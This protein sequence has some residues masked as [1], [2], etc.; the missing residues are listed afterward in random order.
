M[1][2]CTEIIIALFLLS[3]GCGA[4]ESDQQPGEEIPISGDSAGS[5][6]ARQVSSRAISAAPTNLTVAS[7]SPTSIDLTWEDAA[8]NELIYEIERCDGVGC[9][10]FLPV[11]RSPLAADTISHSEQDLSPDSIYKFQV[12]TT[13][14]NGSSAWLVSEEVST[15]LLPN[16]ALATTATTA[17]SIALG[18]TATASGFTGVEIERCEGVDCT[19]FKPIF[20]S[21]FTTTTMNTHTELGL[22]AA[23]TYRFR[24]RSVSAST[25][26]AWLESDNI[27]TT[28]IE[29][30]QA[31][32][33]FVATNLTDTSVQISWT[34]NATNE[35]IYQVERCTGLGCSSFAAATGSP[36]SEDTTSYSGSDLVASTYYSYRIRATGTTG[37]SSW[38]TGTEFV[39]A[40][41][42]PTALT[43]GTITGSTIQ[44]SWTDSATDETGFEV[45][46]C[47]GSDCSD[48]AAVSASPLAANSTSHTESSLSSD[49]VYRFR[50]R[51]VRSTT[52]SNWVTSTNTSTLV[53][54]S[55]CSAP[56]TVV[57][58]DGYKG[59][60]TAV[61]RGLHSDTKV[62]PGTRRPAVAYYDGSATGGAAAIKISWWNGSAFQVENVA[63]DLR[64]A[65]GS[66]TWVRL[67][68]LANGNPMIFWT[69]GSTTVKGAMRSAALGTAGTWTAAVID[70][71]TGAATRALEVSVSPLDQVGIVYLTNTTTAGRARF[72]YCG[73]NCANLASFVPMTAG[74]DT[75]ESSNIVAAYM[76]TGIGWC[77]H[78][79]STYYPAVTYP[80]NAGANVR[81]SSCRGDLSTC[82]TSAGWSG[83]ATSVVATAGVVAKLY[84][85]S[86][87][88]G[89]NPKILA[90]NA[91]N[92]LLQAFQMNQACNAA[93]AYTFTAGNTLGAATNGNAWAELLKS[94]NGL[95]HV[96]ANLGTTNVQYLNSVTT[97]FATTTWNAAG[98]IDTL[99]LPAAGAGTGG[100]DINNTDNQLYASF[101]GAAAPFNVHL[102]VVGDITAASNSPSAF[103]YTHFP[104]L[105]GHIQLP[106]ASGQTRNVSVAA[107]STGKPAVAYV[108]FSIGTAAG[109]A[110]KYAFRDGL[111]SSANWAYT[112]IPNTS[113][114]SFPSL[115]F[116]E[117]D[118][119]WISYYDAG[120]FRYYLITNSE[121]DG[122]G[123][124]SFYQ[125]PINAKTGSA[126]APATDDTALAMFYTGGVAKPIM[127]VINS[128]AAGGTGVRAALFDKSIDTFTN[129]STI[130]TLGASYATRLTA[131]FDHAGNIV[132]AY[133]DITTTKAKFN[134]STSGTTWLGTSPQI[135]AASAGREGLSIRLNPAN[136]RPAISYY[137]RANNSVY[138][139]YCTTAL[140]SCSSSGNWATSTVTAA[141][142]VSGIAAANEQLL[143][144]SLSFDSLGTPS[145]VYM[146][147]PAAASQQLGV[148]D[149]SSGSFV[150]TAL[151]S[152]AASAV[153]GAAVPNFAMTGLN[154][155]SVRSTEG[156]FFSAYV[157]PNNWL[158]AT[159]CGD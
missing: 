80:G 139:T 108:D 36:F 47:S 138:Y 106:L 146:A 63:G 3:T 120:T 62:I 98:S 140:A 56:T 45:E 87:I 34:D 122:S 69:T 149:N 52:K 39:S 123:D 124:W 75:I 112:V 137:D 57:I 42:A 141:A 94:T 93:P 109:A 90:R 61:G 60:T 29:V 41:G 32:S 65:A 12:R 151:T 67:A 97:N 19:D 152:N 31:P 126:V 58:D 89:D 71:V 28:G 78:D 16:S 83:Q 22:T 82:V 159:S 73:A 121:T 23:T 35:L 9:V 136:D 114:P 37:A 24:I 53:A 70:T 130:D 105:S 135:T 92:T 125:F 110:L 30:P 86:S 144:T 119:P 96:V 76:E 33:N 101:G 8:V 156:D 7:N 4:P 127:I 132:V 18:W 40:P 116:D 128:T 111:S 17:S 154:A 27:A 81:Y 5:G 129:Y 10:D 142:G 153:S 115:A 100:A 51:A 155:H 113:T 91:G 15:L 25:M 77:K 59:N 95:F 103:F 79:S 104:D 74:S 150:T 145:V 134:Y 20:N 64:V 46:R 44:I 143:S 118:R 2:L 157:G 43:V 14:R 50:V 148:A 133:Y 147:G 102:G 84:I 38:L 6:V 131:D 85:D 48:F 1:R 158:Y 107:T 72:I 21:P 88:V 68:F 117:N 13:N 49:T 54:A 55:S 66:A 99:T 11:A 26:T